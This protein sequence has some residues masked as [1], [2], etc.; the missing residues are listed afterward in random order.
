M[1]KIIVDDLFFQNTTLKKDV[2]I[3]IWEQ[4]LW[5]LLTNGNYYRLAFLVQNFVK[6]IV[7]IK[8]YESIIITGQCN[9]KFKN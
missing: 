7:L 4:W 6:H 2:N 1:Y 8:V 5:Y 3:G 9:L